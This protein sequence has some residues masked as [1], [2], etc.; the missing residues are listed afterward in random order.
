[1]RAR[2][3][4]TARIPFGARRVA[5]SGRRADPGLCRDGDDVV[6]V[7]DVEVAEEEG[8]RHTRDQELI[9]RCAHFADAFSR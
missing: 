6:V 7:D 4:S 5:E 3:T 2:R 8:H 1:M 9:R